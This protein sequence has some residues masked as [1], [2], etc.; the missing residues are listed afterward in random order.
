MR[1]IEPRPGAVVSNASL[2]PRARRIFAAA[3]LPD[4]EIQKEDRTGRTPD[5]IVHKAFVMGRFPGH[6]LS[7]DEEAFMSKEGLAYVTKVGFAKQTESTIKL[8]TRTYHGKDHGFEPFPSKE[9][10]GYYQAILAI[11]GQLEQ[12]LERAKQI[13]LMIDCLVS[14]R[15]LLVAF[16]AGQEI[17]RIRR[18]LKRLGVCEQEAEPDVRERLRYLDSVYLAACKFIARSRTVKDMMAYVAD[19]D[20]GEETQSPKEPHE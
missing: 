7:F 14:K 5:E 16:E 1:I 3:G 18:G 6:N 17:I 20:H 19:R 8:L 12:L 11:P 2:L 15:D 9:D 13:C 4:A 10:E